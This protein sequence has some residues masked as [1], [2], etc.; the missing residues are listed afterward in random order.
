MRVP[1]RSG[2]L[3]KKSGESEPQSHTWLHESDIEN[4]IHL[5]VVSGDVKDALGW[6]L[7][8]GDVDG[9][10][11]L[12]D[13]LPLDLSGAARRNMEHFRPQPKYTNDIWAK[14]RTR[15]QGG[16]FFR[17]GDKRGEN[18]VAREEQKRKRAKSFPPL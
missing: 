6:V 10:E 3:L 7:D 15:D 18:M 9:H 17:W 4:L 12:G 2:K 11:V 13:L 5:T 16:F 8:A 14:S 1:T